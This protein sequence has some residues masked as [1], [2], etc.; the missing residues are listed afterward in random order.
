MNN[1]YSLDFKYEEI[2]NLPQTKIYSG[3]I[4]IDFSEFENKEKK[5][6]NY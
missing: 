5:Y 4:E 6:E 2:E 3:Y 1:F